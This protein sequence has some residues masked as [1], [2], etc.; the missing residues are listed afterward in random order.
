MKIIRP[1]ILVFLVLCGFG[2]VGQAQKTIA[3]MKV[4]LSMA[5]QE[6]KIS[7]DQYEKEIQE[8]PSLGKVLLNPRLMSGVD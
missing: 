1:V 2:Y 5:R 3:I 4:R 6:G 8:L 7:E